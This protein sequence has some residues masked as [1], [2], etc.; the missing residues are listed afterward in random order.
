MNAAHFKLSLRTIIWGFE[1]LRYMMT[2]AIFFNNWV[3]SP[4]SHTEFPQPGSSRLLFGDPLPP[5]TEDIIYESPQCIIIIIQN[6]HLIR[7]FRNRSP[8]SWGAPSSRRTRRCAR[9]R[10]SARRSWP[11]NT[12]CSRTVLLGSKLHMPTPVNLLTCSFYLFAI[13]CINLHFERLI[14]WFYIELFRRKIY[15]QHLLGTLRTGSFKNLSWRF[16]R[17]P[18]NPWGPWTNLE[19][20]LL[21]DCVANALR[22]IVIAKMFNISLSLSTVSVL[23]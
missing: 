19:G 3:P 11:T 21:K 14:E 20:E 18:L 2:T 16:L 9:G 6:S 15:L 4:F 5:S 7:W 13:M 10:R 1:L 8:K 23:Y 17:V 22:W 12:G